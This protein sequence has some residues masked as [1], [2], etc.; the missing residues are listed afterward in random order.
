MIKECHMFMEH[1]EKNY[2][3]D[4]LKKRQRKARR[5]KKKKKKIYA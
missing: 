2:K 1:W 4:E 5:K 3:R